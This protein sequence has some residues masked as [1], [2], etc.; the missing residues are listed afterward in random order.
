VRFFN[1]IDKP[2]GDAHGRHGGHARD[3]FGQGDLTVEVAQVRA[4]MD[5]NVLFF[6][7]HAFEL[8]VVISP[9]PQKIEKSTSFIWR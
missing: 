4:A 7:Y 6:P 5:E 2:P 3:Q 9:L 1:T 8:I